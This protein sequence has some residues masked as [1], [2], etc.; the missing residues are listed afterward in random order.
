MKSPP[1]TFKMPLF[2]SILFLFSLLTCKAPFLPCAHPPASEKTAEINMGKAF[3]IILD[4]TLKTKDNQIM[5][6]CTKIH[7]NRNMFICIQPLSKLKEIFL[8]LLIYF[9]CL[10][11]KTAL[12]GWDLHVLKVTHVGCIKAFSNHPRIQFENLFITQQRN[13]IPTDSHPLF[14]TNPHP[15][16]R[17]LLMSFLWNTFKKEDIQGIPWL[18]SG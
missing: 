5:L 11:F 6:A 14:S 16:S 1:L 15:S 10:F 7:R 3:W 12:L 8:N 4:E 2:Y 13:P 18:S 9:F 17:K